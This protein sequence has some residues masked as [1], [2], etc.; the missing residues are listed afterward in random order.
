MPRSTD[1]TTPA[2]NENGFSLWK[3]IK[4]F[5]CTLRRRTLKTKQ[6]LVIFQDWCLVN[7]RAWKSHDYR[8][9]KSSFYFEKLC[10]QSVFRR[11]IIKR[12]GS[13]FKFLS[14]CFSQ[15]SRVQLRMGIG[16]RQKGNRLKI[17]REKK[18]VLLHFHFC[19]GHAFPLLLCSM[20]AKWAS[21]Y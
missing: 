8:D 3:H 13:V 1:H 17:A 15:V 18:N 14:R 16:N 6:W 19:S 7:T 20:L 11:I 5:P 4:C 9:L 2:A 21:K 10:W 12:I